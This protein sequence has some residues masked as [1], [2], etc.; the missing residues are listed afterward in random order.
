MVGDDRTDDWGIRVT[1]LED[2]DDAA[3]HARGRARAVD[4][5]ELERRKHSKAKR[6]KRRAARRRVTD[7]L[8]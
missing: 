3:D 2:M 6:E 4:E 1:A 8:N 5:W 7:I